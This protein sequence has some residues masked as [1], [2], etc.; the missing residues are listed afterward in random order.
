MQ[1]KRSSIS[2]PH[3]DEIYLKPGEKISEKLLETLKEINGKY[4]RNKN[5]P[6]YQR[7]ICQ[8]FR[9]KPVQITEK[10]KFYLAGFV[11]GEGSMNVGAKKNTTSRF[12]VYLDP[13]FSLTQHICGISNLYLAM[14][15]FQ[16]GRIRHKT[17]S[18]ATM[19]YTIENRQNLKEKV[20]PFYEKYIKPFGC[21]I[22][23][24][25]AQIFKELLRLFDEK[26]HLDF[27]RMFYEVLPLWDAIRIQVGQSNQTFKSLI[28]AQ[29]YV[30][31]SFQN[32]GAT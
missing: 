6:E 27:D 18:N 5:F 11:E 4:S 16:T 29:Q 12:K 20:L 15:Y 10:S 32:D 17:G 26:A 24:R 7:S 23:I 30:K 2:L 14:C 31:A 3:E 9:L 8:L 1:K 28:E 25:R 19:V 13:E 21:A 22:K